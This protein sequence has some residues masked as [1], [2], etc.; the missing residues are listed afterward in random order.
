MFK[1]DTVVFSLE[2]WSLTYDYRLNNLK[3]G[4]IVRSFEFSEIK[5]VSMEEIDLKAGVTEVGVCVSWH[6]T[7]KNRTFTFGQ[8]KRPRSLYELLEQIRR[9]CV[10]TR[11][12][13]VV[14]SDFVFLRVN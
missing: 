12:Y 1:A 7:E 8:R 14:S 3:D 6:N 2:Y 9:S 4:E 5:S 11:R 13:D 10:T